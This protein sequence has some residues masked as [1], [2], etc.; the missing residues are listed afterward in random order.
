MEKEEIA[1][2]IKK[3]GILAQVSFEVVGNPKEHVEGSIRDFIANIEKDEEIHIIS[4][5]IGEAEAIEGGL[6][7]TFADTEVLVDRLDKFNW[8]CVNFMPSHIDII[9]PE[10]F[11]IKDKELTNWFNDILAK[12]HEITFSYR[13]LSTKEEAFVKNMNAMIH[14]AVMLACEVYHKE[15]EVAK[16]LGLPADEV[17]KF[18]EAGVKK[19]V[20]EKKEGGYF[21]KK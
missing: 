13:T 7:S 9:S 2:S 18:L 4:K 15:D 12:L 20:L 8:L 19:G 14:N 16:K 1:R 21:R 10:E 3:G 6:F 5:E 17:L 11:R